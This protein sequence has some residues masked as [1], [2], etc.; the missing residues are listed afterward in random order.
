[1]ALLA[2]KGFTGSMNVVEQQKGFCAAFADDYDLGRVTE[3]L[4]RTFEISRTSLKPYSCCRYNHAP[5]D[6]LLDIIAVESVDADAIASIRVRTYDIAVTNRPHRT[7]PKTLFDAKM[8]IPFC[9]AVAAYE[10]GAGERDFTEDLLGNPNLSDL[11]ERV[12]VEAD[13][14]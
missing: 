14:A 4:G 12:T 8:S 6:G 3:G 13:E 9:L 7:H 11:A 5:I 10:R 1:S 2:Q